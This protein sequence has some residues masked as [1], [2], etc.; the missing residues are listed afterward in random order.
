MDNVSPRGALGVTLLTALA[1][2]G[3]ACGSSP[4]GSTSPSVSGSAAG[5]FVEVQ[6]ES[7]QV[8]GPETITVAVGD[9]VR[10][11]VQADVSDEVHVHTYDLKQDVTPDE[12]ARFDLVADIP[13][14]FEVELE[15]AGLLL[16]HLE[17]G[18]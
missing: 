11:E 5:D 9:R 14:V 17:V 7:G 1:M 3:A 6:V 10:F 4:S 13:G 16:F 8:R 12:P 15:S 18:G 2:I